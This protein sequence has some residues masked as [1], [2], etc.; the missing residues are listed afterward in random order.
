MMRRAKFT[1][2]DVPA[3]M[4]GIFVSGD[5]SGCYGPSGL[6]MWGDSESPLM[7]VFAEKDTMNVPQQVPGV[8]NVKMVKSSL[9]H[10]MVECEVEGSRK[11]EAEEEA[12]EEEEAKKQKTEA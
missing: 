2:V 6:Y 5:V 10:I 3:R 1:K 11:R 9:S 12:K 7:A 8:T 4:T